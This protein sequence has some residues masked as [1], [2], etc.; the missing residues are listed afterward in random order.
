M[1]AGL[2]A[3]LADLVAACKLEH[4]ADDLEVPVG[5][6]QWWTEADVRAFYESGGTSLPRHR[7]ARAGQRVGPRLPAAWPVQPGAAQSAIGAHTAHP[8]CCMRLWRDEVGCVGAVNEVL[9]ITGS[10]D[11]LVKVWSVSSPGAPRMLAQVAADQVR[12][13][14]TPGLHGPSALALGRCPPH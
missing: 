11:C 8:L 13:R 10:W 1:A 14:S 12:R 6:L 4:F 5:A 7:G 3:G 2:D 9:C